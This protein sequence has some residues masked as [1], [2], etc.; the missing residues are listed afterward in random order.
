MEATSKTFRYGLN[1]LVLHHIFG[2]SFF[3]FPI[4]Q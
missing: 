3:N 4:L 1:L 2:S